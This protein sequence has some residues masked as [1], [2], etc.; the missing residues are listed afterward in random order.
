MIEQAKFVY[1]PLIKVFEKQT[2]TIEEQGKKQVEVLE[3]SNREENKKFI[4]SVEGPF[5]QD[6][7]TNEIKTELNDIKK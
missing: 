1:F 7:R 6:M 4:K 5:S 3:V 2:E